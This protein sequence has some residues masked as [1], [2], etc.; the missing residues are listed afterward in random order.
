MLLLPGAKDQHRYSA[1]PYG[2]PCCARESVPI[3]A[4]MSHQLKVQLQQ[5][6]DLA[7]QYNGHIVLASV[8]ALLP[9]DQFILSAPSS[10]L[11]FRGS[12]TPA[13]GG[14]PLAIFLYVTTKDKLITNFAIETNHFLNRYFPAMDEIRFKANQS[15]SEYLSKSKGEIRIMILGHFIYKKNGKSEGGPTW[16]VRILLIFT[17]LKFQVLNWTDVCRN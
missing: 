4:G 13:A 1:P 3:S 11:E 8:D 2:L 10:K 12:P 15:P 5:G 6:N 14:S 7:G 17:I 16:H 9:E